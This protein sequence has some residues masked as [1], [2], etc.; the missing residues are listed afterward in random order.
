L[1]VAMARDAALELPLRARAV[2]ALSRVPTPASRAFLSALIEDPNE[3]LAPAA[4]QRPRGK[5]AAKEPPAPAAKK[6]GGAVAA[7]R[8]RASDDDVTLTLLRRA[9]VSLGWI[10]GSLA[11]ITLGPLLEHND[12]DVRADAAVAL[13]LTRLPEAAHLL[14]ARLPREKDP[15]VRSHI[16]RQLNVIE[17]ALGPVAPAAHPGPP[18]AAGPPGRA[19]F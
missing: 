7:A 13:A 15:R 5:V 11:P 14:R 6:D 17:A 2:G 18:P 4:A 3:A 19:E 12:P 1:L 8:P 10:G 9:A 16:A